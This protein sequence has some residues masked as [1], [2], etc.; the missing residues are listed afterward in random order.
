MADLRDFQNLLARVQRLPRATGPAGS[1][2]NDI[3]SIDSFGPNKPGSYQTPRGNYQYLDDEFPNPFGGGGGS[4]MPG[5]MLPGQN[6]MAG[7]LGLPPGMRS[8]LQRGGPQGPFSNI[9]QMKD[10]ARHRLLKDLQEPPNPFGGGSAPYS[11]AM[12]P[13]APGNLMGMYR[14]I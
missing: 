4:Y 12:L 10:D 11:G 3:P 2:G 6:T 7:V 8:G 14:V 1:L 5:A 13:G 9:E